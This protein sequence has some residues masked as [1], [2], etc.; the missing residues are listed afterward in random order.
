MDIYTSFSVRQIN[1]SLRDGIPVTWCYRRVARAKVEHGLAM[2]AIVDC[3]RRV[4]YA[5]G[6]VG[7]LVGDDGGDDIS[8]NA[9]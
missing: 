5:M 2:V 1:A 7:A 3:S 9:S 6:D 4:W 8:E